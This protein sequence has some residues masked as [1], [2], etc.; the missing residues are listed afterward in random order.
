MQTIG[1]IGLG[2]MGMEI[3]KRLVASGNPVV[4][5]SPTPQR[6]DQAVTHGAVGVSSVR[7]LGEQVQTVIISVPADD[8]VEQVTMGVNG[9]HTVLQPNA[10][11]IDT[12]TISPTKARFLHSELARNEIHFVDAPVSG[13]PIGIIN[14]TLSVMAGGETVALA[15]AEEVLRCFTGRFVVCGG[16]GSG[17]IAKACNQLIVVAT[18]QVVSEAL[19]LAQ[20]AGADVR[21]VREALLGGFAASRILELQ[22]QR[23]IDRTFAPGGTITMQHKDIRLINDLAASVGGVSMPAFAA[24]SRSVAAVEAA[25]GGA[26]DHS[27]IVTAVEHATGVSLGIT[28]PLQFL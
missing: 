14:A 4:A 24:A 12:S 16:P 9:L 22:G 3:V 23:M 20:A 8:A 28:P 11:I 25:G 1:V 5:Y 18:L 26:L 10:L 15:R 2:N 6:V 17:Q 7:A 19:V 21:A 27:A 13:G